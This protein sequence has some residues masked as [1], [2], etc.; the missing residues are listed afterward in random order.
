MHL[1]EQLEGE[2]VDVEHMEITEQKRKTPKAAPGL[3]LRWELIATSLGVFSLG[4]LTVIVVLVATKG[5]D[6]LS[7]VA[8]LLAVLSFAAQLIVTGVQSAS[9][10]KNHEDLSALSHKTDRSL[11]I[12]NTRVKEL[13]ALQS[14]NYDKLLQTVI[15]RMADPE[16]LI[17]L[18]GDAGVR[19]VDSTIEPAVDTESRAE[20]ASPLSESD[21][22][23][24]AEKLR[25]E[26]S[27]EAKAAIEAVS[28]T[29]MAEP[30]SKDRRRF[31]EAVGTE[32]LIRLETLSR[33]TLLQ[34]LPRISRP[35]SIV[36]RSTVTT[37]AW[38]RE[39]AKAGLL[40]PE[41]PGG[42]ESPDV[43]TVWRLT[44]AGRAAKEAINGPQLPLSPRMRSMAKPFR[45]IIREASL[46]IQEIDFS[47][48]EKVGDGQ[49][50]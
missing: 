1:S 10:R 38:V 21:I 12:I 6:L 20:A 29:A 25:E 15:D 45:E 26:L 2:Q 8:L 3:T 48:V 34:F 24:M 18:I 32:G 31:V 9:A 50:H 4:S 22:R 17:Q 7:A 49:I 19:S 16:R 46:G 47:E 40:K 13:V 44:A 42:N 23:A 11:T 39:V 35:G 33:S 41:P 14:G 28:K 37:P 36:Y 30:G 43:V 27:R 5:S